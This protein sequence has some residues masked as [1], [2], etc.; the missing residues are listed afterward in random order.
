MRQKEE[1]RMKQFVAKLQIYLST[2]LSPGTNLY[3]T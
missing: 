2:P 3:G 1:H